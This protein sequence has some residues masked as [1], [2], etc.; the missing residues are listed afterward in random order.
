MDLPKPQPAGANQEPLKCAC[1]P[2]VENL[3][4]GFPKIG[5]SRFGDIYHKTIALGGFGVHI[6]NWAHSPHASGVAKATPFLE[7]PGPAP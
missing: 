4:K 1:N 7:A 6:N 3:C 5:G 2:S